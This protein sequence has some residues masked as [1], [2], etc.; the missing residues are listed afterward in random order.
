M[1][2]VF[3]NAPDPVDFCHNAH[4]Q[5][6]RKHGEAVEVASAPTNRILYLLFAKVAASC[7]IC[8]ML[9]LIILLTVLMFIS[10]AKS[11]R[12]VGRSGI[13]SLQMATMPTPVLTPKTD[14]RLI[15]GVGK[16]AFSGLPLS[17]ESVGRRKTILT[18]V[19]KD[20]IWTL[21]Q[22][23][24]IIN[25]NVPV[26]ST[27]VK[28]SAKAGGGLFVNNP[29]AP[30]PECID[31]V[32]EI[33]AN[34]GPVRVICLSTLAIEHKGTCGPFSAYFPESEVLLQPGQYAFPVNLPSALF[35]PFG[36]K[37]SDIPP[38]DSEGDD[39][40]DDGGTES[41]TSTTRTTTTTTTKRQRVYHS[42]WR[43]DL[44]HAR[45]PVLRP[46]GI[47]GFSETAFF[48]RATG[49][50]LVTDAVQKIEDE[51]PAIIKE[52]PRAL[53]YHS[54]DT[55][56]DIVGDT[57]ENRR[58]GWRRMVLFGLTFQPAGIKVLESLPAL[59]A[60]RGVDPEMKKLGQ[61]AI[62]L[63]GGFY[64]WE[65]VQDEK[66]AFKALQGGLLVAPIL[67]KLILNREPERVLKW[68]DRVAQWKIK[69]IIPS[70]L[71]ND[72]KASSRDFRRAFNFLESSGSKQGRER[73][74]P[75]GL[76]Q[77]VQFLDDVSK[78]LTESGVLFP[79]AAKVLRRKQWRWW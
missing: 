35:F 65:W 16:L 25:V 26:R 50:L 5:W 78:A 63:D 53:L 24:G 49:T 79:A 72:I 19:V 2:F 8:T 76:P 55:M 60:A 70:H 42:D 9:F 52:D 48:H 67:Q 18:E 15:F 11:Y 57:A 12:V 28:L 39:D 69:R 51:P 29:V 45:M 73:A 47:G 17:P 6:V 23:Q 77:D 34:H 64:P 22:V 44:D 7:S 59:K 37:I 3:S 33:E 40:S 31:Y 43:A 41:S 68:A 56:F 71:A 74:A 20:T 14:K 46:P 38:D 13:S 62:P 4:T 66:P 21:D 10:Q 54:R 36:K 58:K 61:G 30:T 27:I 32:R 1:I 75:T